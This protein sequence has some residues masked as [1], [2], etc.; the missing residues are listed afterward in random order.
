MLLPDNIHPELSIYYNGA[1][2]IEEL[3]KMNNLP[4]IE[5]YQKVKQKNKMSFSVFILC[6]DWLYLIE[7]A[8]VNERG[9]VKLC[10]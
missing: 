9:Y 3:K 4:I 2:I 1:L 10:L 5:L 6:I 8:Q 7:T